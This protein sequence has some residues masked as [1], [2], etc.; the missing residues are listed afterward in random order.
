[1]ATYSRNPTVRSES[2]GPN[3]QRISSTLVCQN[4][5]NTRSDTV[6]R[7]KPK[8]AV[9]RF[10]SGTG[11]SFS[12]RRWDNT[13]FT[14]YNYSTKWHHSNT[15]PS[16][17][18][19]AIDQYFSYQT[20]ITGMTEARNSCRNAAM[21]KGV[22]LALVLSE[23]KKTAELFSSIM[24]DVTSLYKLFRGR[25]T[26]ISAGRRLREMN[27]RE[28]RSLSREF[29]RF[30]YGIRPLANDMAGALEALAGAGIQKYA[31]FETGRRATSGGRS[32]TWNTSLPPNPKVTGTY[33][34][35]RSWRT[36]SYVVFKNQDLYTT[37]GAFGFS[38]PVYIVWELIPFS[39]V[40][41]WWANI[42]EVLE[43]LDAAV[44]IDKMYYQDGSFDQGIASANGGNGSALYHSLK[45]RGSVYEDNGVKEMV[46]KP[47]ASLQHIANGTALAR[48]LTRDKTLSKLFS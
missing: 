7:V 46:Y 48:V 39:F 31:S 38:N 21:K 20:G 2:S 6:K 41:D 40:A 47:S 15:V 8:T 43:S 29:L 28:R 25:V 27:R 1:M 37:L 44:Y 35:Q 26:K 42:G 22:N 18:Y 30:Q 19:A 17:Y 9:D 14:W 24:K 36:K 33:N 3:N 12:V 4:I 16:A 34:E 23:Y 32:S 10:I 11:R 5:E 45:V 13:P